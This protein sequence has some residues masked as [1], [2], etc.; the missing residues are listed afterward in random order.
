MSDEFS[1]PHFLLQV[2]EVLAP[3]VLALLSWAALQFTMWIRQKTEHERLQQAAELASA[4]VADV[5]GAASSEALEA[6]RAAVE[7][8]VV[9]KEELI[10]VRDAALKAAKKQLGKSAIAGLQLVTDDPDEYLW[11]KVKAEAKLQDLAEAAA[12]AGTYEVPDEGEDEPFLD[13]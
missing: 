5:V 1:L 3:A 4:A 8:G 9:T 11:T 12:L 7:D 13:G 6:Y 10:E 2:A